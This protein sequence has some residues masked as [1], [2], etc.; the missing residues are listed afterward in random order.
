[1]MWRGRSHTD[2][3]G[4]VRSAL[5]SRGNNIGNCESVGAF[6][7]MDAEPELRD[8]PTTIA[9]GR[10]HCA[11]RV[12]N[13]GML[14][15]PNLIPLSHQHQHALALCVQTDRAMMNDP[16]GTTLSAL[17]HAIVQQFDGE[18]RRHFNAEERDLFPIMCEFDTTRDLVTGLI[19]DH[20]KIE[21][22]VDGLRSASEK[23]C[24]VEFSAL[25]RRHIRTEESVLFEE[26]QRLLSRDQLA[27]LGEALAH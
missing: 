25:L 5:G 12:Y 11:F 13:A 8:I 6:C 20:R 18:M 2:R 16:S 27:Q 14:R 26:A 7:P 15:D 1:M 9:A 17:A 19:A 23:Q 3:R 22:L 4:C 21:A 24:I 10:H